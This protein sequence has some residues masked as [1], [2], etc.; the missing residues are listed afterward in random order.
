MRKKSRQATYLT[1]GIKIKDGANCSQGIFPR[2]I[3]GEGRPY[4]GW[5]WLVDPHYAAYGSVVGKV[6]WLKRVYIYHGFWP[7]CKFAPLVGWSTHY[8]R[9]A[10]HHLPEERIPKR[11]AFRTS[12]LPKEQPIASRWRREP[13]WRHIFHRSQKKSVEVCAIGQTILW[14]CRPCYKLSLKVHSR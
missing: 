8:Q 9:D 11:S 2:G 10:M 3:P 6:Q 1:S 5:E 12:K 4:W 13:H 7:Y 14:N